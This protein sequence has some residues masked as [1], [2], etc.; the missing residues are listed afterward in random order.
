MDEMVMDTAEIE[1][2][3]TGAEEVEQPDTDVESEVEQPDE[4]V[5]G[6]ETEGDEP[7]EDE[8]E[9][10]AK[11]GEQTQP[12]GRKMPDGLKKAIAS[13]KAT[14]PEVAKQIKGL[15]YSDQEY[16]SAF[17]TPMEAQAAK[18]LIEEIGGPEGIQEI[19]AER[20]E[21][22]QIDRDFAEGKEDFVKT[23]RENNP[24]AFLKTAPH[25]I[26]EFAKAAPEQYQYYSNRLTLNTM[27]NA[28]FSLQNLRTAYEARKESD[29]GAAAVIAE[30]YNSMYDMNQKAAEFEQKRTD[31]REEQLK[32]DR[33][34]FETERRATFETGV[35]EKAERFLA[36]KMK[37]EL[38]RI[39]G[40]RKVDPEA[41][42]EFQSMVQRK[43][44]E[45]LA[46]VPGIEDKLE[47]Y[48]RSGDAAKSV[49][50]IQGQYQR[51][52][53]QAAKTIEPFLRNIAPAAGQ[54]TPAKQGTVAKAQP[55]EAGTIKLKE[56]PDWHELDP[57]WSS[58]IEATAMLM[59]GKAKLKNGRWATG[60]A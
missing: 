33:E 9:A 7:S 27:A 54:K 51:L 22:Q 6:E 58:T 1:A 19:A 2:P 34:K 16:R 46:A 48:Y 57:T 41:M 28:G 47:A 12:D 3:E 43:V 21:W 36:D 50:Y 25:V 20:E 31:P 30:I 53:P 23:L 59:E 55:S 11:E 32:Q 15:Y 26:N 52:L 35:A 49:A 5:E 60:W 44:G 24:E 4:E 42:K 8:E 38:D 17:P 18:G 45:L 40:N 14:S 10:E 39:I 37:P 29:P 13:L 56:M